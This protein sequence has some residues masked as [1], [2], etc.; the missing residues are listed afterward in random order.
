VSR[1]IGPEP[2]GTHLDQKLGQKWGRQGSN[3]RP[4]DY[5]SRALTTELLPLTWGFTYW[6]GRFFPPALLL[7]S[8]VA[9]AASRSEERPPG[10]RERSPGHFELRAYN[11]V[12][13]LQVTS[14]ES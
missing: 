2:E 14:L 13:G 12:A 8:N 7:P 3:L 1:D 5:E 4:R 9:M 10:I 11:H 6:S